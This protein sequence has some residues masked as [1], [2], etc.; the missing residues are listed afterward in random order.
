[1]KLIEQISNELENCEEV[2]IDGV[3]HDCDTPVQV[4]CTANE[5]NE[6][7]VKGGAIYTPKMATGKRIFFKCDDCFKEDRILRNYNTDIET[8]SRVVGYLRP[9]QQWNKGK[10]EE[11]KMRKEYKVKEEQKA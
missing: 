1:M 6:I 7:I 2:A 9:V 3:C 8:Y 4:L 5:N 10:K 11:F